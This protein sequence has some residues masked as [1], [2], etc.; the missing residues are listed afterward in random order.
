MNNAQVRFNIFDFRFTPYNRNSKSQDSLTILKEVIQHINN[1]KTKKQKAI[2][3]DR[4]DN[5]QDSES[6]KLF[7]SSAAYIL[8]DKVYKCRIALIRDH[9]IPTLVNRTTYTLT[10][11]DELGNNAIAETTNFYID[12]SGNAPV[13]CC[14]FNSNGPR[15]LDIE[16][17]FRYIASFNMLKISKACKASLH[18]DSS[19][20]NVLDSITD[21]LKFR[22]KSKPNRLSYLY[23]EVNDPFIANMNALANTVTPST[24]KVEASFREIGNSSNQTKNISAVNFVKRILTAI[25]N[26]SNVTEEF[27][28]FYLEYEG[29]G[30]IEDTFHLLKGKKEITVECSYKSPGNYNTKELYDNAKIK[31]S[32]YMHELMSIKG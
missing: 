30:G 23:Q 17:Y 32:L 11:F 7:V 2:V 12:V 18:M 28:D 20:S 27:D 24:L 6:R 1:E 3:I 19:V 9:K 8:K 25:K 16:Y 15:I 5:R 14:E 4:H 29:E 26:D 22:I 31:F 10:P 13:V 21:V